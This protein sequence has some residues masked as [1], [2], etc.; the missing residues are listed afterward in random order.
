MK[1]NDKK[2]IYWHLNWIMV[3]VVFAVLAVVFLCRYF[4]VGYP[5]E[6][7]WGEEIAKYLAM[8]PALSVIVGTILYVPFRAL[9]SKIA[10]E[11]GGEV[12][13]AGGDN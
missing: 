11:R 7:S 3:A 13:S 6:A 5:V 12:E 2:K 10:K 1:T 8:W 4:G 9:S